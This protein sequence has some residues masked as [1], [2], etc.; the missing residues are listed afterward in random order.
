MIRGGMNISPAELEA[1]IASH[2]AVAEVAVVGYPD[3]VL[4]EKVCAVAVTRA[5]LRPC[6]PGAR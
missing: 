4:G 2:A 3:E 1:L 6:A 5:P